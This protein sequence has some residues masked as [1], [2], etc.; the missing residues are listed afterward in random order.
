[1][2]YAR[3]GK[4][5]IEV[6]R[7][8]VGCMSY[9]KASDDFQLWTLPL[10]ESTKMIAHALD[11][12][13]NFF[14]TANCYSHGTSEEYLG[15]ALKSLGVARDKVWLGARVTICPGVTIGEGAIVGAGAVVTKDVPPCTVVAGVPA[16]VIRKC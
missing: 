14:D 2:K 10:E 15:A 9:G 3:L 8:C 12:G 7:I 11:L 1:M 16:K 4:T 5:D 13:V 6:S